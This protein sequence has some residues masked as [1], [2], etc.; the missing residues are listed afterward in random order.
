MGGVRGLCG[1]EESMELGVW[2]GWG[3]EC[4]YFDTLSC[5]YFWE[6]FYADMC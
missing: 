5:C 1:G 3:V 4:F 6:V 2:F